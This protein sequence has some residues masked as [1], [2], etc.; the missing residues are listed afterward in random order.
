MTTHNQKIA[1]KYQKKSQLEHILDIPDTYIGSIE[2]QEELLYIYNESKKKI[3]KKKITYIAGLQRI[4]E[5]ILLNSFDQTVRKDTNT[6]QIKVK[7]DKEKNEITIWN[8]GKGIPIIY[9]ESE[10]VYIPEMIFGMLL[11]S[12]N[13]NKNE[14][15]ITGG[16]NGYGAK[17]TNIFSNEFKL[18]TVD[19]ERKK[20]FK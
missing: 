10:K 18:E 17:L 20:K 4:F 2:K 11:T 15:R 9:K 19:D 16:K 14:K 8:N 12:G 5:E 13:Y 7:I 1:D 3:T 6:T